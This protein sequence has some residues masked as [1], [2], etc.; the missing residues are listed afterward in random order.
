MKKM[1][2]GLIIFLSFYS[3]VTYAQSL[4]VGTSV[5][6]DYYRRAQLLGKLDATSSF[7]SRPLFPSKAFGISVFYPDSSLTMK[8]KVIFHLLPI[9]ILNQYNSHHPHGIN[10]GSIIPSRGYQTQLSAGIYFKYG[11][12]SVQLR[13]E[14]VYAQNDKS[15]T[16]IKY[17]N[18][19]YK[20]NIDLPERFG[21]S[22][23]NETSWGQSSIRLTVGPL[24]LGVSNEN[25]WWG[26]GYRN[27]LLMTNSA[28]GFKHITLNSVKPIKTWV[29]SFEGQIIAGKL[30]SSG[31][32]ENIRDEWRY[33]NAMNLTYNPK[34]IPGLFLGINRSFLIYNKDIGSSF[35]G[36]LPVF[37]LFSKSSL[38]GDEVV[39]K[40]GQNQ[41]FS[42]FMRW[43]FIEAQGEI[44]FEYG[45]EDHF[46]NLTDLILEPSHSSGYIFGLHKLFLLN[47]QKETY[48][49][50]I[51]ESTHLSTNQTSINRNNGGAMGHWYE[52][53]SIQQG[54]THKGQMLGAGIGPGSNLQTIDISWV[55]SIKQIGIQVERYVHNNDFWFNHIK[56]LRFNW[57]D[58]NTMIYAN[59][60]YK[61]FLFSV[62][63]KFIKSYNY[64]WMYQ[65]I[66]VDNT[67]TFWANAKNYNNF[68]GQ[69]GITYR[70]LN[71]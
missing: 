65:P 34:W 15:P 20:Y 24:S 58:L 39:N 61:N 43:L 8:G 6:E 25:L 26:P 1:F 60:D 28:P 30:E 51:M 66:Y 46:W 57:V 54:Y 3:F 42:L 71:F 14:F 9:N 17:P 69:I 2:F 62:K 18:S 37:N 63:F 44:Y 40:M 53:S 32:T 27:T 67:P 10:D 19:L 5:L 68:Q 7:C 38:G 47:K 21:N 4:P 50:L 55:K 33:I 70:F 59:W 41:I 49:Q 16:D 29:G 45:R 11:P 64:Q 52:H 23:Y 12:L 48:L 36:Y 56:D 22:S 13:P 35:G 31:F